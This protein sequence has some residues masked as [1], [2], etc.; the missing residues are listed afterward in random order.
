MSDDIEVGIVVRDELTPV[1]KDLVKAVNKMS[2]EVRASLEGVADQMANI[3]DAGKG[4][5]AG[6]SQGAKQ[7]VSELQKLEKQAQSVSSSMGVKDWVQQHRGQDELNKKVQQEEFSRKSIQNLFV[8]QQANLSAI[9]SAQKEVTRQENERKKSI[10]A[11]AKKK[12]DEAKLAERQAKQQAQQIKQLEQQEAELIRNQAIASTLGMDIASVTPS[13]KAA[14]ATL[15]RLRYAL[16]DVA[17]GFAVISA[18]AAGL[19]LAPAFVAVRFEREFADVIRTTEGVSND[20]TNRI[21]QDLRKL[22]SDIPISWAEITDIATLA[23]QLGIATGLIADFSASVARFS[24]TTDLNV[25]QSATL[26]GRLNQ[27]IDGIDGQFE[28]LSSSINRVG[29]ISV[30]TESQIGQV[31]QNIASIANQAGF[32]ASEV[33]GLAGSL[34][35]LGIAPELARGVVT[36]L[37]ANINRNIAIGGR[38]LEEFGRITKRTGQEFADSWRGE[39]SQTLLD[40]FRGIQA[41]GSEAERTLRELGITSVRDTPSILRLAQN[42]ELVEKLVRESGEAFEEGTESIIQY[43][44]ITS[45]VAEQLTMLGQNFQLLISSV[46]ESAN[47]LGVLVAGVNSLIKGM[48]RLT[49]N[50][51]AKWFFGLNGVIL[52]VTAAL[53]GLGS[54][55]AIT[56]AKVVGLI[57]A[58][59]DLRTALIGVTQGAGS[60]TAALKGY[61]AALIGAEVGSRKLASALIALKVF[62]AIAIAVGI[63]SFAIAQWNKSTETS[64]DRAR[65]AFGAISSF[66]EA[67]KV[68]TAAHLDGADAIATYTVKVDESADAAEDAEK[69]LRIFVKGQKDAEKAVKN[70]TSAL[71]EQTIAFGENALEA[72]LTLALDEDSEVGQLVRNIFEDP[73]TRAVFDSLGIDLRDI[74][75]ASFDGAG[76]ELIMG[77]ISGLENERESLLAEAEELKEAFQQGIGTDAQVGRLAE[78]EEK[79]NQNRTVL[80]ETR[81]TVLLVAKAYDDLTDA[82]KENVDFEKFVRR[83]MEDTGDSASYSDE[84]ISQLI[85]TI[86]GAQNSAEATAKAVE[87]LGAALAEVG[88]EAFVAGQEVQNA[89]SA[90]LQEFRDPTEAVEELIGLFA[91][92]ASMGVDVASPAMQSLADTITIVGDRSRHTADDIANMLRVAAGGQSQNAPKFLDQLSTGFDSVGSSARSAGREVKSFADQMRDAIDQMFAG[93]NAAMDAEEAIFRLGEA[94]AESGASALFASREMQAAIRSIVAASDNGEEAVANLSALLATLSGQSGV[95]G[96]SLE[97]LRQTIQMVGEQAG[98]SAERINQLMAAA[99]GGLAT[100][101]MNNFRRGVQSAA[102]EVR[103]LLDFASDLSSVFTRAFDIRFKADLMMDGIADTWDDLNKQIKE[104]RANL[105]KLSADRAV[106]EYFL[107]IAEAYGDTL[108]A[109]VIRAEIADLDKEIADNQARSTRETEG[110][111]VEARENRRILSGLVREYQ[112]YI[113]ALAESGAS[114]DELRAATARVRKEFEEQARALGFQESVIQQYAVAFDDVTFAIDRVPRNVTIEA[115]VNPALTALRELQSQLETNIRVANDLNRALNQPVRPPSSGGG[116]TPSPTPPVGGDANT[117]QQA[118]DMAIRDRNAARAEIARLEAAIRNATSMAVRE[119]LASQLSTQQRRLRDAQERER[120]ARRALGFAQGGFTGRGGK[121]DPAGIVHKGEFVVP[122]EFVNQRTGTPEMAFLA[123]MQNGTRGYQQGG[124]VGM[125]VSMPD[126]IMVE[127]SAY[128]RRLLEQAGNVE[129]RL[130]GR[131]LAASNNAKNLNASQRGT[132]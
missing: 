15:P 89:I 86:F 125:S 53:F 122:K 57:T 30:A 130:D 41:E 7:G 33:I 121:Y 78:V 127:L 21:R 111:T 63:A 39:A 45:T 116:S 34:A 105:E 32:A 74:V 31:A 58:S 43:N 19:A 129:L 103:T 49:E 42:F 50:E 52:L 36:R 4:L 18:A 104:A 93:I 22:A 73:Q 92:L 59:V 29:V 99:G 115:D 87:D 81:K 66:S 131:V 132:N 38:N 91:A 97:I 98:L 10:E 72:A 40:F 106:K 77:L 5:G 28:K 37:F 117:A 2:R 118:L 3:A 13:I 6:I 14:V 48:T 26:F 85:D 102:K 114:Q 100:V 96:A 67:V 44:A 112:E 108:R 90:I 76:E 70:T 51:V 75:V 65:R 17:R 101:R 27:L 8:Q 123:Q 60:A 94:F 82:Q 62:A 126:A 128:D 25:E 68:D 12:Q 20:A 61:I 64:T 9:G 47:S 54:I 55:I 107:S 84:A 46:G 1:L 119:N 109:D 24:A 83:G 79:L 80:Q 11:I 23:G 16:F 113:G 69:A 95:T 71:E 56:F 110:N 88:D 35:S 124:P 120:I